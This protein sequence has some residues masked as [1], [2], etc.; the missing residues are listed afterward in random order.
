FYLILDSDGRVAYSE[1][2][3]LLPVNEQFTGF[4]K[5]EGEASGEID[6]FYWFMTTNHQGWSIV[7][8]I[9]QSEYNKEKNLWLAQ[10]TFLGVI[11]GLL[12][13]LITW[14]VWKMVYKPV[15]QFESEI[16][17]VSVKDFDVTSA[18]TDVPEF[19]DLLKQLQF[20]KK[21]ISDLIN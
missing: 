14:L 3:T 10:I 19:D 13:L 20:M 18:T 17:S 9:S 2:N 12:S 8:L 6:G 5:G 4:A 16:E 21:K 15:R 11:F 7:S 1:L